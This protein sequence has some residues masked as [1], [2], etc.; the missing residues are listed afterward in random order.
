[1]PLVAEGNRKLAMLARLIATGVLMEK[2]V[3]FWD[4]PEANLNPILIREVAKSIVNLSHAGIQVFLATHSLFL[5][6]E[7]EILMSDRD[8]FP[9]NTRFLGLHFSDGA[10]VVQQ[11]NT[12]DEIGEI[13]ALD[14]EL[15]QSDRFLS[16]G[17]ERR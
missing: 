6:R 11:G 7:L 8:N 1:M 10:V 5:L 3:L 15:A 16:M 4:E 17:E 2:G 9:L 13:T 14:Q 12:S